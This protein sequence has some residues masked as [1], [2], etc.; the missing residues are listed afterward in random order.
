MA[1]GGLVTPSPS[2]IKAIESLLLV[3]LSTK[4]EELRILVSGRTG[5]GKSALINGILGNKSAPEGTGVTSLV[6]EY[7]IFIQGTYI[8]LFDTPDLDLQNMRDTCKELNLV[9]YCTKMNNFRLTDGDKNTMRKYTTAFGEVFW[10]FA[11]FLLTF[12]NEEDCERKDDRDDDIEEPN[13]DD[14]NGWNEL[15]KKRFQ[16]RV[17][18]R[19]K[20]LREF[21]VKE[22]GV[23]E[24][25]TKRIPVVPVG[26]YRKTRKN[27]DPFCL[28][29]QCNWL[30]SFWEACSQ[31][32]KQTKLFLKP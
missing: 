31:R 9:L 32:I 22:V 5:Q 29:D 14:E 2:A 12:A 18:L 20:E 6:T 23:R 25:I 24:E 27:P 8:R 4:S 30:D 7:S 11:V 10:N 3:P 15:L 13:V 19:E 26:D 28:P 17:K 21:L 1:D 16:G